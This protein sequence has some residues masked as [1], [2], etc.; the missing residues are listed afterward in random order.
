MP[1][2][3]EWPSDFLR[4][5]QNLYVWVGT[6]KQSGSG[7]QWNGLDCVGRAG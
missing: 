5:F 7:A 6:C 1:K 3:T 4:D 2:R